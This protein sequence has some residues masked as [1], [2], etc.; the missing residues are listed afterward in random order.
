MEKE[1]T[2][3]AVKDG[4]PLDYKDFNDLVHQAA[5]DG[6]TRI[7][8][9]NVFGQRFIA[10]GMDKKVTID[11]HG[12]PG[13]D[14]GIFMDGPTINV[15]GNA[16]D[17]TGNTMN[18]GNIIIHGHAWDVTGLAARG[19]KIFIKQESGY[20]VGIHMKE[21]K[22]IKPV[23]VVGGRVREFFGEYMAGGI[24]VALGLNI[25]G[26]KISECRQVTEGSLG[27]GI[28][29]GVIYIRG[30]V[31]E[32]LLGVGAAFAAF[33]EAD[34]KTLTPIFQEFSRHF[35]IPQELIWKRP[36]TK[37]VPGSARPFGNFYS[38]RQI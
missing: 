23:L 15:Y 3:D 29:G 7:K 19:G 6:C 13:N 31:D 25:Q 32:N 36:F 37:I 35:D 28:H 1:I 38:G 8:L 4:I 10:A 14:L 12:T 5:D 20:R 34:R 11:I 21:Y 17:H 9:I 30:E 24:L 22:T 18:S 33:E 2:L 26:D 16:E 27:T